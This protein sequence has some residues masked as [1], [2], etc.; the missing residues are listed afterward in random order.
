MSLNQS[1]I[2][3]F[4]EYY[5]W[6]QRT[7]IKYKLHYGWCTGRRFTA[8]IYYKHKVIYFL[9]ANI[10]FLFRKAHADGRI[11]IYQSSVCLFQRWVD[12]GTSIYMYIFVFRITVCHSPNACC[13]SSSH[14]FPSLFI[15]SFNNKFLC[16]KY[17]PTK[18]LQSKCTCVSIKKLTKFTETRETNIFEL[19]WFDHIFKT[20][21]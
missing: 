10:L 1:S 8:A 20:D 2:S 3:D 14:P 5:R 12:H 17:L 6:S 19:P 4:S 13:S 18:I 21:W 9:C 15:L 7:K 16:L 11:H